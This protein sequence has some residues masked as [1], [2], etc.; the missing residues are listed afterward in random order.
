MNE[1]LQI[2][3]AILFILVAG[4][5]GL[6]LY[7]CMS[8]HPSEKGLTPLYKTRCT[9]YLDGLKNVFTRISIYGQFMVISGC[10][11]HVL[12]FS[13]IRNTNEEKIYFAKCLTINHSHKSLP[14]ISLLLN[15]I[16]SV[17]AIGR[18]VRKGLQAGTNI[19]HEPD[20]SY[21]IDS[22][23]KND[24]LSVENGLFWEIIGEESNG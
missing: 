23:I 21:S 20:G 4:I 3:P 15:D 19:L 17:K 1:F 6:A 12:N 9:A 13:D 22:G 5:F 14:S 24:H 11:K 10:K 16:G 2:L 7:K 18:K 8:L